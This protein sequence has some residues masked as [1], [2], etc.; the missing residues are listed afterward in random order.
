MY[1]WICEAVHKA[2]TY[3]YTL[4]VRTYKDANASKTHHWQLSWRDFRAIN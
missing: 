3:V 2:H 4:Y 1:A